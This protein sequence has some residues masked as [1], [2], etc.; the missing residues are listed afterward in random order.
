MKVAVAPLRARQPWLDGDLT[1]GEA[2]PRVLEIS[3]R[4]KEEREFYLIFL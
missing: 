3:W 4:E 1:D 2:L